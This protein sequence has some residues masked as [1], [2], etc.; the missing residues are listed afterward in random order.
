AQMAAQ[1]IGEAR[2]FVRDIIRTKLPVG[3]RLVFLCRSHRQD[4][5]DPPHDCTAIELLPF[6]RNETQAFL[7]QKFS[8][9][10]ERDVDEFHRLS[11]H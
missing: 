6:S 2:S 1:E 8:D 4:L 3:V 7:R 9:A 5:L 10:S 11:S